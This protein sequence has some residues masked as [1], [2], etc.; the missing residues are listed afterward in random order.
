MEYSFPL[1]RQN[2]VVFQEP[3]FKF[4]ETNFR[5]KYS[6]QKLFI[7]CDHPE[8]LNDYKDFKNIQKVICK[9]CKRSIDLCLKHKTL[10][11][12][13]VFCLDE[14][15]MTKLQEDLQYYLEMDDYFEIE[16]GKLELEPEREINRCLD[17]GIDL[18]IYNPRQF[19]GKTYCENR[20]N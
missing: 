17:C 14:C 5:E 13:C 18:G 15:P 20:I 3:L 4:E 11:E 16:Q 1:K 8:C 2:A 7:T 12:K 6:D 10:P 9:K 19:C